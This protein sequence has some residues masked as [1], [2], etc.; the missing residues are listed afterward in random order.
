MWK[1][2][3]TIPKNPVLERAEAEIE[4]DVNNLQCLTKKN[5]YYGYAWFGTPTD[6]MYW[7]IHHV[8]AYR[9]ADVSY[10]TTGSMQEQPSPSGTDYDH[11]SPVLSCLEVSS[12]VYLPFPFKKCNRWPGTHRSLSNSKSSKVNPL[13]S[14]TQRVR[15]L[16]NET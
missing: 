5:L 14:F 11:Q 3:F 15:F 7:A 2:I 6:V 4:V 12:F 9:P 16:N 13:C 8:V 1:Q 10:S